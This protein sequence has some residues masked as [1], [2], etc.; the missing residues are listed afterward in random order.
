MR[1]RM[2]MTA[3]GTR[4]QALRLSRGMSL[5]ELGVASGVDYSMIGHIEHARRNPTVDVL[6]RIAVALGT[7]A[8]IVFEGDPLV[9]TPTDAIVRRFARIAPRIPADELDVF[10]HELALW[11]KRYGGQS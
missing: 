10:V 5:R 7:T 3:L 9:E 2:D 11:E 8:E 1:T 4:L 6:Q